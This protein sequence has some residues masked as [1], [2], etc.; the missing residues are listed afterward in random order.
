MH[1]ILDLLQNK[2]EIDRK[3][4]NKNIFYC[5]ST[6][7]YNV[8]LLGSIFN[9]SSS[10]IFVVLPNIYDAQKYYNLLV[11]TLGEDEVLFYPLDQ[12]LTQLMALGSIEFRSER[13]FS[14][15]CLITDK[16][17]IVV[18]T[19][20]G[21]IN[22]ILPKSEFLNSSLYLKKESSYKMNKVVEFLI[23]SGYNRNYVVEKPLEFSQRGEIIDIYPFDLDNPVRLD[24]NGDILE[25]IKF[26]DPETQRSTI[27]VEEIEIFRAYE[28]FYN[29]TQ[30]KEVIN[31]IEFFFENKILSSFEK[32]KLHNDLEN[33]NNRTN[34]SSLNLYTYFFNSNPTSIVDLQDNTKIFLLDYKK[35][36]NVLENIN[37]E[38]MAFS[39][40]LSGNNFLKIPFFL[41]YKYFENR[42]E[43]NIDN[44]VLEFHQY[45]SLGVLPINSYNGNLDLLISDLLDYLNSYDIYISLP[46]S[47]YYGELVSKLENK[48]VIF[49]SNISG[50]K[51]IHISKEYFFGSFIDKCNFIIVI[52]ESCI[53]KHKLRSYVKFRS[54][55]SQ[56]QKVRNKDELSIGDFV[57]H[58]D[59]GIARY[60]GI[61]Q[62]D[63][64]AGRRDFLQLQYLNNK[65]MYIPVDSI[66]KVLKYTGSG[67]QEPK[68]SSIGGKSWSQTRSQ[69]A[70]KIKEISEK[71]LKIYQIRDNSIGFSFPVDTDVQHDFENDFE[72]TLTKDQEQAIFDT[73]KDME[74]AVPM[75]RLICGDVGYGKTEIALRAAMK[76]IMGGKQVL[77]LVPTT[78]L[79]RQHF[80]TFKS[81]FEKYSGVVKLLSR[82]VSKKDQ[83]ETIGKIKLGYVDIVIGTHR[84]LSKDIIFRNLGLLI[85]D[86]EQRF[87]VEQKE[88]I[89]EIKAN[90]DTL[91]LSATP[92][93]R[94]L[95]MSVL[96]IKDLSIIET[97]PLNRY[98]I[99]TY[100]LERNEMIIKEAFYKE[101]S[102]GGQVFYLFNRIEEIEKVSD[103]LGKLVPDARI[104]YAH[105]KL[106]KDDLEDVLQKFIDHEF[107]VL[108]STTIIETGIDIPNTNTL[109]VHDADKLGLAQLYQIRGR[110]GRSDKIAYAYLMYDK[111]KIL[112]D[113][114]KKRLKAILEFTALGSGYKIAKRDLTIRGAGDILGSEQSGFI[115]SIGIDLYLKLL[116]ETIYP[117][118][119][120]IPTNDTDSI[121]SERT[122]NKLYIED[123]SVR[124]EI[125]RR[126]ALLS[127]LKEIKILIE[128]L[129]DRFGKLDENLILYMYDKFYQRFSYNLGIKKTNVLN[130]DIYLEIEMSTGNKDL[131]TKI[132]EEKLNPLGSNVNIKLF[133][134]SI[135]IFIKRII[136]KNYW[137]V[138]L[139]TLLDVQYD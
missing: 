91:T 102:R 86:E 107:D 119:I 58:F 93:P 94:T 4:G 11:Q 8:Y 99:Q 72:Y 26:F 124:I 70:L 121:F 96:G 66:D 115:D 16:K 9:K 31:K 100:V 64:V 60:L 90:V 127:S 51:G 89:K 27:E 74:R 57:V 109:I 24:F 35:S 38:L 48:K 139:V 47:T 12:I 18:T 63:S 81:R 44:S 123:D 52:D 29:D 105:G 83:N 137:L 75:D 7:E 128:E 25:K 71:L 131:I 101:L 68:L 84:V 87:G 20:F 17:Y 113:D 62:I 49:D 108:V 42:I 104:C 1:K 53:F 130:N 5:D 34:L 10:S 111:K 95:Q 19:I 132:I 36:M 76:A 136:F 50:T 41:D 6:N 14:I 46:T 77:Y 67:E 69:I 133:Q 23:E 55:I 21:L 30:K 112:T 22:R 82:F 73:K 56:S 88:R 125:H 122:I 126:I 65:I 114:A 78:I 2:K 80:Y 129:T 59:Y 3:I 45:K 103:L 39:S 98:P 110:I 120:S 85:I 97:P 134:N 92:I 40:S 61:K 43:A 28:L 118:N 33:L 37:D 138:D 79:A 13:L 54:V 117:E 116:K 32:D 135:E 15:K 106:D